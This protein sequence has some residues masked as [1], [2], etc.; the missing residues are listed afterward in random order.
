MKKYN[1]L[2]PIKKTELRSK[3]REILW[4]FKCDCGNTI[5]RQLSQVKLGRPKSCGCMT[6]YLAHKNRTLPSGEAPF[7]QLYRAYRSSAIRR[8]YSFDLSENEFRILTKQF[9]YYCGNPP[10]QMY[11]IKANKNI[12]YR[13]NG[14][15]RLDNLEGYTI[16]NCVPCCGTCNRMKMDMNFENFSESIQNI[17]NNR[18]GMIRME[19]D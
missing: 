7:R 6:S 14:I 17:Y 5:I 19:Q 16:D 12:P 4:E 9:C 2:T 11:K 3:N 13:Y 15:D 8:G 1:Y 10:M 18:V